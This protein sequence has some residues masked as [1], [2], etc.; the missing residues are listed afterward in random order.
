MT[1]LLP[2]ATGAAKAAC[3]ELDRWHEQF[4]WRDWHGHGWTGRLRRDVEAEAVAASTRMEGVNVTVDEVRRILAGDTPREVTPEDAELVTG[5]REAMRFAFTR[6]DDPGFRWSD[7]LLIAIQDRAAAGRADMGAG[8]FARTSRSLRDASTGQLVFTP[9]EPEMIAGL[10]GEMSEQ[11][12]TRDAHPAV[13]AAWAHV[14]VAAIHPFRDGNGRT[15]RI[16]ASLAMFRGGYRHWTFTT[17][18]SWW[19]SHPAEYYSAFS[20]LGS[21]FSRAGDVT[22]FIE[23]HVRA[24]LTQVRSLDLR[25]KVEHRVHAAICEVIAT[26]HL[27]PR[28]VEAV[29]DAFWS[30]DV[31]AGY[32]RSLTDVSPATATNDLAAASAAGLLTPVGARRGRRYQ[33]GPAI[34]GAVARLLEIPL[35]GEGNPIATIAGVLAEREVGHAS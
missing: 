16:A 30:R 33:R 7:D 11:L 29:W 27:D 8:R 28:I 22:P 1:R 17:L 20:C 2:F 10:V 21:T 15:A 34:A 12:N 32:Y 13:A 25:E 18:E 14:A 6:A 23:V 19:G 4:R 26:A 3:A 24:Q 5:Y 9:P 35:E 31:T